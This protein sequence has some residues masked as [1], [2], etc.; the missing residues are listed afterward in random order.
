MD[1]K[2]DEGSKAIKK[3]LTSN[4]RATGI[5]LPERFFLLGKILEISNVDENAVHN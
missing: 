2:S 4:F 1:T 3:N 5:V